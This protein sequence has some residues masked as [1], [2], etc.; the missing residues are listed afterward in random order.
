[1][2]VAYRLPVYPRFRRIM[3]GAECARNSDPTERHGRGWKGARLRLWRL[4]IPL[5]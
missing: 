3:Q 1:M 5:S 2:L 4:D